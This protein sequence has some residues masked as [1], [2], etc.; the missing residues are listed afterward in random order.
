[1]TRPASRHGTAHNSTA[2]EPRTARSSTATE[3]RGAPHSAAAIERPGDEFDN[4]RTLVVRLND[5]GP[6]A[7]GRILDL[8][9]KAAD[10]L[11]Y[12]AAGMARVRVQLLGRADLSGPG[13]A[14]P[15]EQTPVEVATAVQ[16][17]PA[18]EVAAAPLAPVAGAA[19][20]PPVTTAE[21]PAPAAQPEAPAPTA[22]AAVTGQVTTVPV[23]AATAIYVQ[24]GAFGLAEN[25]RR[26]EG[27]LRSLGARVSST[28]RDGKTVYRVRIGP[29]QDVSAAD[30]A[31]AAAQAL[32]QADA[33]IVIE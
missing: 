33:R 8:S 30:A 21:L 27:K 6:Y 23:P 2:A 12:R 3:S 25:A 14:P 28:V 22:S 11:G 19:T 32:G 7:R 1:M 24:A 31:L 5:R 18:G 13:L 9:E 15:S 10:L 4:G 20:A 17:A 26:V 29:L 16:A